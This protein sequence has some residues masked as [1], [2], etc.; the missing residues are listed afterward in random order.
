MVQNYVEFSYC[1]ATL[2]YC[3]RFVANNSS[4]F[5]LLDIEIKRFVSRIMVEIISG[6]CNAKKMLFL[7]IC[8]IIWIKTRNF[9]SLLN[10]SFIK[11]SSL[12]TQ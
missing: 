3:R 4:V 9:A 5:Y 11:Q 8:P 1:S 10:R 7:S 12:I 2:E 6:F